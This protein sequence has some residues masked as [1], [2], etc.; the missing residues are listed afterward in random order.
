MHTEELAVLEAHPLGRGQGR[1]DRRTVVR[2]IEVTV[3]AATN[4]P[5]EEL[6]AKTRR[7]APVAF[8]RQIAM[9]RHAVHRLQ[10]AGVNIRNDAFRQHGMFRLAFLLGQVRSPRHRF[11]RGYRVEAER[12]GLTTHEIVSFLAKVIS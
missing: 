11:R 5:V 1:I 2:M 12:I 7:T 8:A 4:L 6:S 10:D 9:C 3:A